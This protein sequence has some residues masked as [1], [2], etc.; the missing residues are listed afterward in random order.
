MSNKINANIEIIEN[1]F[2][3]NLLQYLTIGTYKTPIN[4]SYSNGYSYFFHKIQDWFEQQ[5]MQILKMKATNYCIN[6]IERLLLTIQSIIGI[7]FRDHIIKKIENKMPREM[8]SEFTNQWSKYTLMSYLTSSA[9]EY[10]VI[11]SL[12]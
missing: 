11:I 12:S 4:V 5:E 7:S 10:I 2:L 6:A 8:I 9:F 1:D 3:T